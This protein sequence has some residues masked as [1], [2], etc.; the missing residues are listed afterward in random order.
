MKWAYENQT[1]AVAMGK[2][3]RKFALKN[4]TADIAAERLINYL[5]EKF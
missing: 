4:F 1:K 3:A 5:S 2:K